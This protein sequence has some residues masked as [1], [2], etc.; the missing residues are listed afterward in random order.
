MKPLILSN[1]DPLADEVIYTNDRGSWNVSRALR[2]CKV[3]KH[4]VYRLDVAEADE[5]DKAA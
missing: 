4:K 5:A 1:F 3:G 2:D